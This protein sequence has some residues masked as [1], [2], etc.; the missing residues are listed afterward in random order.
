MSGFFE[1]SRPMSE[2]EHFKI[3]TLRTALA[4]VC[5]AALGLGLVNLLFQ[6]F[7]L[8][9]LVLLTFISSY[10]GFAFF[11]RA[12]SITFKL[13]PHLL[14]AGYLSFTLYE[15]SAVSGADYA[16]LQ[17]PLIVTYCYIG[18]VKQHARVSAGLVVL[19][20]IAAVVW[21][22]ENVLIAIRMLVA[23]LIIWV[24]IDRLLGLYSR[25][26]AKIEEVNSRLEDANRA[27]SDFLANV[28]HEIRTPLNG[29]FGSLQVIKSEAQDADLV[30]RYVDVAMGS[31]RSV[32]GIVN[33]ILDLAKISEGK[34]SLVVEPTNIKSLTNQVIAESIP[35][36]ESRSIGLQVHFDNTLT[37]STRL[38]DGKAIS[39]VLRNLVSNAIKFT[40]TG[41]VELYVEPYSDS[42]SDSVLFRVVDTGVG[43]PA[44]KLDLIFESFEQVEAARLTERR[45]TGLGLAITKSLVELMHGTVCVSSQVGVGTE[46]SVRLPLAR[47][48]EQPARERVRD[49]LGELTKARILLVEDVATNRM[50]CKALLKDAPYEIDEAVDGKAG[51]TAALKQSYDLILMD[52][53]MPIMDG[54]EALRSLKF[55][56]YQAPVVACT[57]NV[58]KEDVDAYL[59]AGFAGV[60][61][62][63]Y[64]KADLIDTIEAVRKKPLSANNH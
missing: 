16:L 24:L 15:V 7:N 4:L 47:T 1:L 44:E 49:N 9:K 32:V 37:D 2:L 5:I 21:S 8:I 17:G 10:A 20:P 38:A 57:A 62:K 63:P 60:V 12:E 19:T 30:H 41:K 45:G 46:F 26:I 35:I 52:I 54:F 18:M 28:S 56:G 31:Y 34:L 3:S 13:S 11:S 23:D 48:A 58:M 53:Q 39:Q 25:S 61:G 42:R 14:F 27:K 6:E 22:P 33:D 59:D 36:A 43:I 64:L 40:E 50:L 51:V 29:I 55:A